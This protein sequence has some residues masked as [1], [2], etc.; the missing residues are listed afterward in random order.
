VAFVVDAAR[1]AGLL[2]GGVGAT[3]LRVVTHLDA[4]TSDCRK[5]AEALARLIS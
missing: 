3:Q 5:A 1:S 2:V 4:S